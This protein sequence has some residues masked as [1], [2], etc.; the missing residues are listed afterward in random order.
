MFEQGN[1]A[2]PE[3]KRTDFLPPRLYFGVSVRRLDLLEGTNEWLSGWSVV[4]ENPESHDRHLYVTCSCEWCKSNPLKQRYSIKFCVKLGKSVTETF[5][6]IK[7]AY[8]DVALAGRGV[9]QWHQAFL[10]G[11][12]EVADEDLRQTPKM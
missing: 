2:F 11:R 3:S 5:D 4:S 7:Q 12:E 8:P 9:F 1:Q 10:K 6:M